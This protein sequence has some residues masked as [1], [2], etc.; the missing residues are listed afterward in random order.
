MPN[1]WKTATVTPVIKGKGQKC[2]PE[3]YRPI[4]LTSVVCKVMES[5]LKENIREHLQQ[6]H[7]FHES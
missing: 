2:D 7:W 1:S 4:S 6:H 5:I 3:S